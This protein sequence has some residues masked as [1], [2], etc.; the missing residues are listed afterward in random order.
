[1]DESDIN[2]DIHE[3]RAIIITSLY[4]LDGEATV[5]EVHNQTKKYVENGIKLPI[6]VNV[7]E[8]MDGI[9][10]IDQWD[11]STA[12]RS[13]TLE[14]EEEAKTIAYFLDERIPQSD[15]TAYSSERMTM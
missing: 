1:M 3:I 6:I 8:L 12:D 14:G 2:Q 15:K 13:V 10:D 9:V 11:D 7:L 4:E 5:H